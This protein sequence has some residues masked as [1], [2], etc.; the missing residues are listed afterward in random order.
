VGEYQPSNAGGGKFISGSR[1][2]SADT[3]DKHGGCL[4]SLLAG[5]AEAVDVQLPRP[6]SSVSGAVMD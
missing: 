1:A 4:Q 2:D 3:T 5:F 6:D